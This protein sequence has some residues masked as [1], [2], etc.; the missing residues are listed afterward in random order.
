MLKKE[1]RMLIILIVFFNILMLS[2]CESTLPFF[3]NKEPER[4]SNLAA[5]SILVDTLEIRSQTIQLI[6]NAKKAIF[7]QLSALDD[8]EILNLLVDKSQSGIE[9]RI[10]LDQ[11]QRDNS[12]TV[13]YLKNRNISVQYYPAQ[14][15]QY[16]RVRYMVI[17][18]Q[19]GIFYGMD[20]TTKGFNSHS[21]AIKLTGDTAWTMVKSFDKDWA[22]TTTLSLALPENIELPEDNITF[23]VNAGV[24]QQILKQ[25]NSATST[26]R[27][28]VEQLSDSETVNALKEAKKRGCEIKL[29]LSSS[30]AVATPNTIKELKEAEIEIRYFNHPDKLPVCL[31]IGVFDNRTLIMTSSSWTYYSFV[32]NHEGSLTIPSPSAIEKI[33]NLFALEWERST[34]LL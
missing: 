32:I 19:V 13:K 24:K 10:L 12:A 17:D 3:K 31:N 1:K 20:W 28:G 18:Y 4:L 7:I 33:N 21:L 11:W 22:Y 29:I 15:G 23:T 30:C 8:P 5:S 6:S 9:I 25:I 34:K 27:V 26:I 14:K 2:G 16:Q